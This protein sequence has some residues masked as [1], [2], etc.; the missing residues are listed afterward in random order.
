LSVCDILQRLNVECR[1]DIR[2]AISGIYRLTVKYNVLTYTGLYP[3]KLTVH[4]DRQKYFRDNFTDP[5]TNRSRPIL[6]AR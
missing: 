2:Q 3:I 5:I 1:L 6:L 4:R